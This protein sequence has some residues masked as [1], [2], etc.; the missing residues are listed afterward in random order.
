MKSSKAGIAPFARKCCSQL[1]TCHSPASSAEV[2]SITAVYEDQAAQDSPQSAV[3]HLSCLLA[4]L[5][6]ELEAVKANK[7]ALRRERHAL[8]K[9][10]AALRRKMAGEA[11]AVRQAEEELRQEK[12]YAASLEREC[13][14]LRERLAQGPRIA[15][16]E[17]SGERRRSLAKAVR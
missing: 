10:V 12:A 15:E 5:K 2:A 9:E 11:D 14:S 8:M 16:P 4:V 17:P 6:R 1:R 13:D 7:R 3:R